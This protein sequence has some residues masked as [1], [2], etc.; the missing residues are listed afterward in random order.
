MKSNSQS[1]RRP[2]GTQENDC[3]ELCPRRQ[4]TLS[5]RWT[6]VVRHTSAGSR[7]IWSPMTTQEGQGRRRGTQASVIANV[8]VSTRDACN[9][10]QVPEVCL[11]IWEQ[12]RGYWPW[13]MC[14]SY[15]QV[16]VMRPRLKWFFDSFTILTPPPSRPQPITMITPPLLFSLWINLCQRTFDQ[17]RKY[18][19]IIYNFI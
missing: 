15:L 14:A 6:L 4:L 10:H 2:R 8:Y 13:W 17:D 12:G 16:L 11:L 3:E 18:L 5:V 1:A 9:K 19:Y 7:V